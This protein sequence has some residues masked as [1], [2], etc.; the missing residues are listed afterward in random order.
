MAI[1]YSQKVDIL[2][3]KDL[4]NYILL[5]F[6]VKQIWDIL[7]SVDNLAGKHLQDNLCGVDIKI[8]YNH[9]LLNTNVEVPVLAGPVLDSQP[10]VPLYDERSTERYI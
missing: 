3:Y 7:Q 2:S 1:N 8:L 6:K 5:G 4:N 9:P 10:G